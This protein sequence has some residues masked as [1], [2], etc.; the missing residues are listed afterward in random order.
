M[1]TKILD[2]VFVTDSGP[3]ILVAL[4][5]VIHASNFEILDKVKD[6]LDA[7]K[8]SD[9]I[10]ENLELYC[11]HQLG[12]LQRLSDSG[13]LQPQHLFCLTRTLTWCTSPAFQLWALNQNKVVSEFRFKTQHM[14][15]S[16]IPE[17][18]CLEFEEL[19]R[20]AQYEYKQRVDADDCTPG[21]GSA[22]LAA[23]PTIPAGYQ[24]ALPTETVAFQTMMC[25]DI[26]TDIAAGMYT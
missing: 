17:S 8:L 3:E 11:D 12:I 19:I 4:I 22:T 18:D 7:T 25:Q 14:D 21:P 6:K 26:S 2:H 24:N 16:L 1:S 23:E 20:S 9:F 10:G 5:L 13:L 15:L